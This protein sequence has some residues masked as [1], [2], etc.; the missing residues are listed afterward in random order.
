MR[1]RAAGFSL[2]AALFLIVI[3]AGLVAYAARAVVAHQH[4]VTLSLL[5]ARALEAAR[6]GIEWGAYRA[7]NGGTCA[8]GTLAL[9]EGVL[10]GFSVQVDCSAS[11]HSEGGAT[12]NVYLI[13]AF[14]RSGV[15][16][17]PD[18][19]SRQVR[20]RITDAS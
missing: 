17:Q 19:V 10:S 11:V 16:G 14:A 3:V 12:V 18:Y 2:V 7:L 6:T 15:Y 4:T 1:P 13:T 20:A 5:G 9:T 8:S